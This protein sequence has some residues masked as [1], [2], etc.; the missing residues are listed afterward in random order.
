MEQIFEAVLAGEMEVARILQS[1]PMACRS[2]AAQDVLVD[3]I[4]H[5]LYTGDTPLHL[6]AAALQPEVTTLLLWSGADPNACNR[7][8]ATPLHYACDARPAS[9]GAWNPE[10]QAEIIETLVGHGA[11]PDHEDQGGAA[12][13]H[14]AVRARSVVAVR[15]L[16]ELGARTDSRLRTH[17]ST[18]LHL[19]AVP[20]GAGGTA[21]SI[22]Q[23]LEIIALLR[24]HGADPAAV[25]TSN[26]TPYER[27]KNKRVLAA[28]SVER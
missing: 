6:A 18:P 22:G 4:P 7:R 28:L 24:A 9:G 15:T 23:Q 17:G 26:R 2:Q 10:A 12:P 8:G 11:H 20:T 21:G 13:L 16:L 25:D 3:S 14:R 27:A 5:W 19:A 1:T